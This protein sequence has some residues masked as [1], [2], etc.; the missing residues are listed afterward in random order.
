MDDFQLGVGDKLDTGMSVREAVKRVSRWWDL[1]GAKQM[2]AMCEKQHPEQGF[3][4]SGILQGMAWDNLTRDEK[5]RVIKVWHHMHIRRPDLLG[6]D[7]DDL[8][9]LGRGETVQ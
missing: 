4:P 9:V 2:R 3:V 7:K 1:R 6:I 8:F 5:A